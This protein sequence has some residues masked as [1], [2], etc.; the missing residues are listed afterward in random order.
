MGYKASLP[1]KV[2]LE[3][4]LGVGGGEMLPKFWLFNIQAFFPAYEMRGLRTVSEARTFTQTFT[5]L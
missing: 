1:Y 2:T 3:W 5:E 4:E